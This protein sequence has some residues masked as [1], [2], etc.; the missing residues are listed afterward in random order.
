MGDVEKTGANLNIEKKKF[1]LKFEHSL[2]NGLEKFYNWFKRYYY[3][4]K[5]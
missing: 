3:E 5:Y 2:T 4:K 1:N